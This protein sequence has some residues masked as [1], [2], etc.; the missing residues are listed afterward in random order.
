[1]YEL[2]IDDGICTVDSLNEA[3][4]IINDELM[5]HFDHYDQCYNNRMPFSVGVLEGS[6]YDENSITDDEIILF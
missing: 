1:M 2:R 5:D 6:L 4:D 3:I